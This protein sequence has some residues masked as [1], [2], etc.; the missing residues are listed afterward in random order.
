MNLDFTYCNSENYN[1]C[2]KCKRNINLYNYLLENRNNMYFFK[3]EIK[4]DTCEFF[5]FK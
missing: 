5:I 2:E 1:F 3:P 4:N